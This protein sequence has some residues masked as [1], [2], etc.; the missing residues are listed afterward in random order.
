MTAMLR[1]LLPL[2]AL[3]FCAWL[4]ASSCGSPSSPG[5]IA[6]PTESFSVALT[7]WV[8]DNRDGTRETEEGGIVPDA[9]IELGGQVGRTERGTGGVVITGVPR[10]T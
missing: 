5:P 7:L 3:P 1:R 4:L 10:G 2:T 6:T 9:S 8:D